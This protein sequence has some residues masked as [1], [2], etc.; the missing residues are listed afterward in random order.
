[1][2]L[3]RTVEYTTTG[4]KGSLNLDPSIVPFNAAVY[5][6]IGGGGSV[7]LQFSL[8]STEVA[9]ADSIWF[10]S[11]N[12]PAGTTQSKVTNLM[13]PVSKMRLVIASI[14]DTITLQFLQGYTTN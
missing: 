4:T 6:D 3:S 11:V 13:F 2:A 5:L 8:D 10:D 12:I 7:T 14:T 9:D 1:M